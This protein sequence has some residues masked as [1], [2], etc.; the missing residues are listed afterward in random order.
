[1]KGFA[2][3]EG[4]Y[5]FMPSLCKYLLFDT[6]QEYIDYFNEVERNDR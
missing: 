6:E 4:Y 3:A 1:M 2:T 5:G